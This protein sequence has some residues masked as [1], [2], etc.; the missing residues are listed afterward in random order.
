MQASAGDPVG[1]VQA[2]SKFAY[3]GIKNTECSHGSQARDLESRGLAYGLYLE[4]LTWRRKQN[5]PFI[6]LINEN[7]NLEEERALRNDLEWVHLRNTVT[8]A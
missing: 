2:W 8:A 7:I 3:H 1:Y 6:C 4:F 5:V